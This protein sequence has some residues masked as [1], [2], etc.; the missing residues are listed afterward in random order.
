MTDLEKTARERMMLEKLGLAP[1][2]LIAMTIRTSLFLTAWELLKSSVVDDLRDFFRPIGELR[3]KPSKEYRDRIKQLNERDLFKASCEWLKEWD[4]LSAGDVDEL[5]RL[6]KLRNRLAHE[7][8][9]L[10]L[11]RTF[12]VEESDFE[13]V[14]SM[15]AKVGRYWARLD[16]DL[17]PESGSTEIADEDIIPGRLAVFMVIL[18][19]LEKSTAAS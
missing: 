4:A 17:E 1:A 7:L 18:N 3:G 16:M 2:R 10:I 6:R 15:L 9:S 13:S 14:Q 12:N 8:P 19:S 11:D 5:L